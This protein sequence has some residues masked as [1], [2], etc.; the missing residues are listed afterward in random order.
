[1]S[2]VIEYELVRFMLQTENRLLGL[3]V[4]KRCKSSKKTKTNINALKEQL[5][6]KNDEVIKM[7]GKCIQIEKISKRLMEKYD[8]DKA[9]WYDEKDKL[10]K[11]N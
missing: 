5:S 10:Q 8:N 2:N 3:G 11:V 4:N 1:M 9:K 7:K 6:N